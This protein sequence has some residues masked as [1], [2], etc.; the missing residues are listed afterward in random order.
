MLMLL[1]KPLHT[2]S[3]ERAGNGHGI[4]PVCLGPPSP[5]LMKV[6]S[7]PGMQQTHLIASLL[8]FMVEVFMITGGG[9]HA[10]HDLAR[11]RIQLAQLLLPS[12][13]TLLRIGK[14][15]RLDHHASIRASDAP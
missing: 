6:M 12:V 10:N 4:Q 15:G 13:P 5:L 2:A 9:L 1:K 7:L 3:E 14:G 8:Q 11:S